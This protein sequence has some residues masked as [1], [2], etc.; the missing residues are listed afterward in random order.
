[1]IQ[2]GRRGGGGEEE[3]RRRRR[4]RK[5]YSMNHGAVPWS[6]GFDFV[7]A[8]SESVVFIVKRT[9]C[10]AL[11]AHL[12]HGNFLQMLHERTMRKT[13]RS[14][15]EAMDA[16]R[17]LDAAKAA[18]ESAAWEAEAQAAEGG[19]VGGAEGMIVVQNF[20]TRKHIQYVADL[21]GTA[22]FFIRG[23]RICWEHFH[24]VAEYNISLGV[25]EIRFIPIVVTVP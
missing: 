10:C 19:A 22:D 12:C 1:M 6:R 23:H 15:K 2:E 11:L 20:F 14:K 18:R 5:G 13:V 17:A 24:Y 8:Q 3:G 16:K 25:E 9:N 21:L 4:K 7:T